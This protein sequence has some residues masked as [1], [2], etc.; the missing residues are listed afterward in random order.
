MRSLVLL[1]IVGFG[2]ARSEQ[3]LAFDGAAGFGAFAK[4]GKGGRVIEITRLDDDLDSP[5]EGTF[6]WAVTQ[7]GP[8]IVKFRVAGTI[9]L[10]DAVEI[11]EPFITIDGQDAPGM[12]VCIRGGSLEFKDTHDII[13]RHIRVRLGDETTLRKNREKGLKRPKGSGGL[14]CIELKNCRDAIFDHISASWSCDELFSVVHCRNVTVQWCLL[15]EPLSNPAIHPYGDNHA[16][17]F[18]SSAN[19]L[20]VHHC[21]FARYVMRGPQFEAN[22]MR[23]GDDYAVQM[24]AINNV[25]FDYQRSGSRY[26]TGIEDHKDEAAKQGYAFQFIGNLYLGDPKRPAIEAV[27]KHEV[28]DGVRAFVD[29]RKLVQLSDTKGREKLMND[30]LKQIQEQPVFTS[31]VPIAAKSADEVIHSVLEGAGCSHA[32]DAVDERVIAHVREKKFQPVL[33]SQNEVGGWPKLAE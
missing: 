26:T 2:S 25:M 22:D 10:Q 32:R 17:C 27:M 5:P 21:L 24:E 29:D 12:G 3:L 4:G 31:P 7:K 18:N 6:R 23:K 14:D 16:F 13:V 20:S 8:R 15:A 33:H 1:F 30:A 11:R 9:Q 28:H 19:T